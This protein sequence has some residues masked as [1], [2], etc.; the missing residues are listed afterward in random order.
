[1]E[2]VA[3]EAASLAGHLALD[4][5]CWIYDN[6]HITIE[7]NTRLAFTEDVAARFQSYGWAVG[8]DAQTAIILLR[9]QRVIQGGRLTQP[10][11]DLGARDRQRLSGADVEGHALPP[12]GFDAQLQRRE[13]LHLRVGRHP[14][15]RS[16]SAKLTAD[17]V[18]RTERRDGLQEPDPFG[19]DGFG[20][21]S[22]GRV[23]GQVAENLEEMIL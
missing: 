18:V 15:L 10:H 6:N 17:H 14:R 16:I 5:L 11:D 19:A 8:A 1:M 22:H 7:G 23:H 20:V 2:G 12:P 3:S 21:R 4:N 9:V 13:R